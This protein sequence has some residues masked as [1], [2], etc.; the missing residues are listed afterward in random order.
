MANP[1]GLTTI[2]ECLY[3]KQ[4]IGQELRTRRGPAMQRMG[5]LPTVSP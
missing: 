3:W 2:Q 1:D 5:L 4:R